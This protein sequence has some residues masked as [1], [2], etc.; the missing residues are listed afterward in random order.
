[1][2]KLL[3]NDVSALVSDLNF[4]I[5]DHDSGEHG[6]VRKKRR[7]EQSSSKLQAYNLK[8]LALA[9][10]GMVSEAIN[11]LKLGILLQDQST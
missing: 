7:I 11:A 5:D 4:E 3:N 10:K 9:H 1:M 8:A 2:S 6:S